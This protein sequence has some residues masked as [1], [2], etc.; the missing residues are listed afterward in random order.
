MKTTY[1][2]DRIDFYKAQQANIKSGRINSIPFYGLD[3]LQS[4]IPGIIPGVM[5]KVTSHSGMSKTQFSKFTFVYQAIRFCVK[6]NIKFTVAYVA[7]E[8]SREEFIDKLFVHLLKTKYGMGISEYKLNGTSS[9]VLNTAELNAIDQCK[10][11]VALMMSYIEVIDDCYKPTEIFN[12]IK[13]IASK[14]GKFKPKPDAKSISSSEGMTL[15]GSN[16]YELTDM[17]YHPFDPN[18]KFLVV[19]DHISLIEEEFNKETSKYLT[20][21]QS[22]AKWHTQ[23]ARKIITKVWKWACLNIQQQSLESEKQQFNNKGETVIDKILPTLDGVANNREVI[24]DDY[25]VLGIFAADRYPIENYR[26]Y[27][28]KQPLGIMGPYL[29]DQLRTIHILKARVGK[30]NGV[31]PLYFDGSYNHFEP[32]PIPDPTKKTLLTPY[33]N[34]ADTARKTNTNV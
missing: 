2:D 20:H 32:I 25:V 6:Y 13:Y 27:Q 16:E 21:P 7:L 9:V 31:I 12:K 34:K 8:E 23:Y 4:Q 14:Y 10:E 29:G 24:R 33:Y 3:R 19:C 22:I 17:E 18:H 30:P 11:D 1:V 26:G 5:Y 15:G 28:V